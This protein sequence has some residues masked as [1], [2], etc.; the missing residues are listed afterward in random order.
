MLS[1]RALMAA[2]A[3]GGGIITDGIQLHLDVGDYTSGQVWAD[4][5]GGSRDFNLGL[6]GSAASD[7]PTFTGSAGDKSTSTYWAFDGG[8]CFEIE[9]NAPAADF[10][11]RVGRNDQAWTLIAG[12]YF[13]STTA[14]SQ[15]FSNG[16]TGANL[17]FG[18]D[19]DARLGLGNANSSSILDS[20]T[21]LSIN[22]WYHVV[23]WGLLDGST[24]CGFHVNGS[25]NGT[26]TLSTTFTTGDSS[27]ANVTLAGRAIDTA[28]RLANGSRM[29]FYRMYNRI[30]TADEI[31]QDYDASAA[32]LGY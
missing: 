15:L 23:M 30:L 28:V 18:H 9:T 8:D 12:L 5:S 25:A 14:N 3:G 11:R 10:L 19:V 22:T 21:D 31:S 6:T 4:L 16:S 24:T 26:G 29:Q 20:N 7:D 17:W 2:S 32:R 13:G 1:T 27:S